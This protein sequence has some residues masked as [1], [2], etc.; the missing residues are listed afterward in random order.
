MMM[1][2]KAIVVGLCSVVLVVSAAVGAERPNIVWV[3]SEDNSAQW[4]RLYSPNGAPMPTIERLARGGLVF[5]HAFSN[6]PVCSVARS[7]II[8][9][10]Y[11]PRVGVQ[12]HRKQKTVPMPDGVKMF[13]YYLR[14]A[15]Y[16]TT[17]CSK[18][19]YNF[20]RADKKGVWDNSSRK[21]TY[22]ERESG[23]PFFHVQNFG[24]THEGCLH[25]RR[26]D[27]HSKPKTDP[28]SVEI[29]SYHPDTEVFRH[30]YARYL[31]RHTEVDAQIGA[32]VTRLEKEGLLDDTF[33]FYY[34]DHGGTLPRGKGYAY[35]NGLQVPMVVYIPENWKHLAPAAAGTR[36]DGFVQFVDL[37]ATVLNLAGVD[38][39]KGIDGRP[40]LGKGVSLEELNSRD[41]AFGYAD[42]FDEKY[43]LVRTLRKGRFN[44]MRNYQ[45][46]NFDGL[47]NNYRYLQPA[48]EE[49]RKLYRTGKLNVAQRQFFETRPAECLYD[50]E[51]DPHETNNLAAD[52]AYA[53]TLRELRASMRQRITSM[54]DLSFVPEPVFLAEGADDPVPYGQENRAEIT[55]LVDIA[56]LSL[57]PFSEAR[58]RLSQAL[59]SDDPL[60]RYWALIA[61]STFGVAA[62]P[63]Y[64]TARKLAAADDSNL[65]RIRAVEFLGL[66]GHA[67]PRPLVVTALE[68]ST[69]PVEVGL[70][71]NSVVLLMDGRPGYEFDLA[72]FIESIKGTKVGKNTQVRR[73][74]EYLRKR[75]GNA[76]R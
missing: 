63:F 76:G 20:N 61:C 44:Y 58:E 3:V 50:L 8:S 12:Y 47:Q 49:W 29:A 30:T 69:D 31:D 16:Y 35:N 5:N 14:E 9:G 59:A 26:K 25:D 56:D 32:F 46:F 72:A 39:P 34:G 4:L 48:F 54:P 60:K 70:M 1:I 17:N 67:D 10:C 55:A 22:R 64:E 19:D 6:A 38:V 45:P 53:D 37:S 21:A 11:A 42:R 57:V 74:L 52:P 66:T 65:V 43:D 27:Y 7:T 73:R 62:A 18:E 75:P 28:A 41:A 51:A 36:I 68:R 2:L 40:F 71:L 23:Q 15:G 24:H 13:P 33:V